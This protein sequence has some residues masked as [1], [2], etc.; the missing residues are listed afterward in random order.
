M[1]VNANFEQSVLVP[2]R[3]HDFVASPTPGVTRMMLDRVGEEVARATTIVR[4]A[5]RSRFP[6]HTHDGGEEF[7][8]LDGVFEDEHGAFPQGS[9][10][11]NPPTS[12]HTPGSTQ[13]CVLFVKLWQFDPQDRQE[14]RIDT[15]ALE[16]IPDKARAGVAVSQLFADPREDVRLE[17]WAPGASARVEAPGGAEILV[18]EG[19]AEFEGKTLE[20]W[21]WVRRA[22]GDGIDLTAG[23]GGLKLWIKTGHL[24]EVSAP[25]RKV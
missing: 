6:A 12:R 7:L 8:V 23:A 10:I 5:P 4:F 1:K 16:P 3:E 2:A 22:P 15:N 20:P 25:V 19:E 24:D 18:I 13:G 14:V 17:T 21:S 11:R 9:Y